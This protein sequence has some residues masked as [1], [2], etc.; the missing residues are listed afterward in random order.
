MWQGQVYVDW[1]VMFGLSSSTGVFS[2]IADMLIAIYKAAGFHSILKWVNNFFV[3]HLPHQH[4][5]E[6]EFM[7]LTGAFGIPWSIKKMCPFSP[8]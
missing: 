7:E 5:S 2:C 8:T 4:W 6:Q 1:A 3:V